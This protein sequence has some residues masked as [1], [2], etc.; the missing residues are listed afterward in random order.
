MGAILI[1]NVFLALS[2]GIVLF[3][4]NWA[5]IWVAIELNTLTIVVLLCY[6]FSPRAVEATSKYFVV[7]AMASVFLLMGVLLRYYLLGEIDLFSDYEGVSY[8]LIMLGLFVKIA[9]FP[10]PFW[11]IDVVSGLTLLRSIYVIVFSKLV[12][13][14]LF[15][16]LLSSL[17]SLW[18]VVIGSGSIVVGTVIGLNQTSVRKIIALSS[19]SHLGWMVVGFPFLSE[20]LCLVVFLAYVVMVVPLIYLG[21]SGVFNYLV[22]GKNFYYNPVVVLC[23]MICL[24]SLGGVP[25]SLGF[26]YKWI[27]FYGLVNEGVYLFSGLLI[28]LSLLSLFFYL[29]ICYS[30]FSYYW[31]E[32]GFSFYSSISRKLIFSSSS[33]G[34]VVI[35]LLNLALVLGLFCLGPLCFFW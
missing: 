20:G 8:C 18:F 30:L 13:L 6:Q 19:V 3:S 4:D 10:N 15:V 16:C 2:I 12:P 25:P 29:Q 5:L 21:G 27:L 17:Y 9:V 23:M 32:L 7:Q 33:F 1:Y 14:Y 24:L 22:K 26:F 35:S 11:F 34:L 31:P 28:I